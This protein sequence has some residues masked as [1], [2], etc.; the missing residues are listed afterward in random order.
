M[1]TTAD[2]EPSPATMSAAAAAQHERMLT[3]LGDGRAHPVA[4]LVADDDGEALFEVLDHEPR[5]MLIRDEVVDLVSLLHGR[6]F[7]HVTAAAERAAGELVIRPDLDPLTLP[8]VDEVPLAGG[9][10]AAIVF[11]SAADDP[12]VAAELEAG[13]LRLPDGVSAT[14]TVSATLTDGALVIGSATPDTQLTDRAAQALAAAFDDERRDDAEAVMAFRVALRW[15]LTDDDALRTAHAPLGDLL[16]AAGLERRGD[17]VG[18]AGEEWQS[19]PERAEA[20][21]RAARATAYGFDECCEAA[22]DTVETAFRDE[23]GEPATR[24][25][26]DALAHG[27]VAAAFLAT[28]LAHAGHHAEQVAEDLVAFADDLLEKARGAAGAAALHVRAVACEC[29]GRVAE[30]ERD[31]A[32]ALRVDPENPHL[33]VIM[34]GYLEDR[35]EATRAH[36]HLRRAGVSD[37]Y[38][39]AARL[40]RLAALTPVRVGRNE[41]CPCGSGRKFKACCINGPTLPAADHVE[42]LYAKALGFV[43]HP[44]RQGVSVHLAAHAV[45][46]S[47]EDLSPGERLESDVR[48]AELALFEEEGLRWFADWRESLLPAD[49]VRLVEDWS[50]EPLVLM[51]VT[52]VGDGVLDLTVDGD[53]DV[54]RARTFSPDALEPGMHVVGRLVPAHDELWLAGPLIEVPASEVD[55]ARALAADPGTAAFEWAEWIGHLDAVEAGSADGPFVRDPEHR[56]HHHH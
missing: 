4:T 30:A 42:W 39:Q 31:V 1:T 6:V 10:A 33:L 51:A 47:G 13:V 20:D 5:F 19:P 55:T 18:R 56:H 24:E 45:G 35:G 32:A 34:A 14:E 27:Q 43:L 41:P 3:V 40:A 2:E 11:E 44:A 9:G 37:E 52:A 38:P 50:E 15:L 8:F 7:T 16:A 54:T 22:Y 36:D 53:D 23:D 49:D 25:V 21:E 12:A 26:A 17:W 28:E 46:R 48:F 29:L